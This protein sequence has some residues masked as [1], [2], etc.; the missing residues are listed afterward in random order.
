MPACRQPGSTCQATAPHAVEDGTLARHHSPLPG[1]V[2]R[3]HSVAVVRYA[4]N[5]SYVQAA[6]T[7]AVVYAPSAIRKHAGDDF[8]EL[9]K[10]LLP[11]MLIALG[12][13]VVTTFVGAAIGGAVGAL[14]AGVGAAPGAVAGGELGLSV[15]LW[16]LEWLGLAFL[17]I[18]IG[19]SLG[20][21]GERFSRGIQAAWDSCGSASAIDAAGREMAEGLGRFYSLLLQAI[22]AYAAQQGVAAA[23]QRLSKT[24]L[25]SGI[26]KLFNTKSFEEGT[27]THYLKRLGRPGEPPLVRRRVGDVVKFLRDQAGMKEDEIL[28]VLKGVDFNS[29]VDVGPNGLGVPIKAGEVLIQN[30]DGGVGRWFTRAGRSTR[31]TGISAEGREFVRFD[32]VKELRGLKSRSAAVVD[33]WTKNRRGDITTFKRSGGPSGPIEEVAGE[34]ASGGGEQFFL[35]RPKGSPNYEGFLKRRP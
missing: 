22:V 35:P 28:G 8:S 29:P 16:L 17:V 23:A 30:A 20:E 34:F 33:T 14:A 27:I 15:G 3:E 18:Y 12:G 9:I 25:G 6:W 4:Q 10:G 2:C 21:I 13:V 31:D 11:A 5:L 26:S 24:R 19:S 32:V 7:R 1:P